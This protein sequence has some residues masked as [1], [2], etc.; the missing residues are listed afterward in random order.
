MP[1]APATRSGRGAPDVR[2]AP[3]EANGSRRIVPRGCVA[4]DGTAAASRLTV[5][6]DG[7][8]LVAHANAAGR[9][10]VTEVAGPN[11]IL[12]PT[13]ALLDPTLPVARPLGR[14]IAVTRSTIEVIG[15]TDLRRRAAGDPSILRCLAGEVERTLR[16]AEQREYE[17]AELGTV[18]R[19]AGRISDL[20]TQWG[21]PAP[22]GVT[23]RP[24]LSQEQWASWL[25]TSREAVG[26]A[27]RR[28]VEAGCVRTGRRH[29]TVLDLD[30]LRR[31]AAPAEGPPDLREVMPGIATRRLA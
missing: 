6:R 27:L 1:D 23:V 4:V 20:A 19:L 5:L 22:V 29:I 7:F 24:E 13:L 8:A 21:E 31:L 30:E 11:R 16:A 12:L 14:A 18:E 10:I 3:M 9:D 2:G 26:L 17:R 28:L 25:G 15:V